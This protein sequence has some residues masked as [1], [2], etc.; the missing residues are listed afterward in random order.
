MME[1]KQTGCE[2]ENIPEVRTQNK[3]IDSSLFVRNAWMA[4]HCCD[5]QD[6]IDQCWWPFCL[7]WRCQLE[8][9]TFYF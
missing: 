2:W 7:Y 9:K 3:K 6:S 4:L 8:A 1:G 5:T